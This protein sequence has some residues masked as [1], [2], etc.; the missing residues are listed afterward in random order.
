MD[1]YRDQETPLLRLGV[2]Y[3]ARL[4]IVTAKSIPDLIADPSIPDLMKKAVY[5]TA[6][7]KLLVRPDFLTQCV[8]CKAEKPHY[9]TGAWVFAIPVN[10]DIDVP[11]VSWSICWGCADSIPFEELFNK[12]QLSMAATPTSSLQ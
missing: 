9:E 7:H 3:T 12:A 11:G 6:L 5:Q 1:D 2:D 4:L 10:E 8:I